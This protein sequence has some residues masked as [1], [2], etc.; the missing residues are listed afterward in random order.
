MTD[1]T[2]LATQERLSRDEAA[3]YLGVSPRTL[4]RWHESRIGP[5]R[6]KIGRIIMY[7]RAALE[8]WIL[9]HEE[10]PVRSKRPTAGGVR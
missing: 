1:E 5:P 9:Q 3:E 10:T 7:R 2:T 6:I 4:D 8:Q